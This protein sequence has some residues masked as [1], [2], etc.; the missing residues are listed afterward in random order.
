ME[1]SQSAQQQLAAAGNQPEVLWKEGE[2]GQHPVH[3]FLLCNRFNRE[4]ESKQSIPMHALRDLPS[5]GLQRAS[6]RVMVLRTFALHRFV[7]FGPWQRALCSS[8]PARCL[9]SSTLPPSP[10]HLSPALACDC[11]FIIK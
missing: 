7:K 6:P 10:R 3:I 1:L 2:K 9:P 11:I 4:V 8:F 5:K